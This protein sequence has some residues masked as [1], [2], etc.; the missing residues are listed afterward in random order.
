[1]RLNINKS[2]YKKINFKNVKQRTIAIVQK[3]FLN[4]IN[5]MDNIFNFYPHILDYPEDSQNLKFQN[6]DQFN[7][8][9]YNRSPSENQQSFQNYEDSSLEVNVE[10]ARNIHRFGIVERQ[11][12]FKKSTAVTVA[13]VVVLFVFAS[14]SMAVLIVIHSA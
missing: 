10:M 1:M 3:N 13:F 9:T 8:Q 4:K 11:R 5:W 6:L 7:C 12:R 2:V 14:I